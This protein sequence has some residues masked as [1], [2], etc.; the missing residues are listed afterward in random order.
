MVA[1]LALVIVVYYNWEYGK[2][3]E[4]FAKTLRSELVQVSKAKAINEV[5]VI[6]A[7]ERKGSV[8]PQML[9]Q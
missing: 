1:I 6:Q 8:L 5:K 7:K 3:Q 4:R 9:L 2:S